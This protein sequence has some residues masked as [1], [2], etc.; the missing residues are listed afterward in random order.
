MQIGSISYAVF[1]GSEIVARFNRCAKVRCDGIPRADRS[2]EIGFS[3][4]TH[5][6]ARSLSAVSEAPLHGVSTPSSP[7]VGASDTALR[8]LDRNDF[9][10]A[11]FSRSIRLS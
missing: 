2:C 10:L 5:L 4:L 6:L 7:L 3:P 9:C 8:L 1:V 11:R